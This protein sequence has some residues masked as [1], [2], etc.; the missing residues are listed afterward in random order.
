MIFDEYKWL[1]NDFIELLWDKIDHLGAFANKEEIDSV[2]TWMT[3]RMKQC[4]AKQA[5]SIIKSQKKKHKKTMPTFSGNSIELDSRFVDIQKG[6]NSF[7]IW[8]KLGSIG[9]KIKILIPIKQHK[10][11]NKYYEDDSWNITKSIRLRKS[12]YADF[13]FKKEIKMKNDGIDVGVDI[14]INKMLTLSNDVVVGEHV[15]DKINVTTQ[16]PKPL[17]GDFTMQELSGTW[18]IL[19]PTGNLTAEY[20]ERRREEI[21]G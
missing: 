14:G 11:F 18:G 9:N 21:S 16:V 4:A 6:N 15:K 12:G 5:I 1:V 20:A 8:L 10:H 7:D 19:Q 3:V 17:S 13:F 2:D